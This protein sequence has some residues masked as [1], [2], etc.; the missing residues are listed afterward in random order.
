[1]FEIIK[2]TGIGSFSP[3]EQINCLKN[4]SLSKNLKTYLL[5]YQWYV[6][7]SRETH[8]RVLPDFKEYR[9]RVPL[10]EAQHLVKVLQL[11]D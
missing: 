5:A 3:E 2:G 6:K 1:M 7:R 8:N 4:I 10:E 11:Q 9:R